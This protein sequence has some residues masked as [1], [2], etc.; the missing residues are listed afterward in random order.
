MRGPGD[1]AR[2]GAGAVAGPASTGSRRRSPTRRP[3]AASTAA[4]WT[5]PTPARP[6]SVNAWAAE[7]TD[8]MIREVRRVASSADEMI[9]LGR[10]RV[11]RGLLDRRRSHREL[12]EARAVHA[13]RR[14]RRSPCPTMHGARPA[15]YVEDDGVQAVRLRL[16]QRRRARVRRRD[17]PRGPRRAGARRG[18]L[19]ARSPPACARGRAGRAAA[20]AARRR[21]SSC[22]APLRGA[23]PRPGVPR[24]RR[25]RRHVRRAPRPPRALGRV[26]HRAR[27][28][29]DEAGHARGR[30]DRRDRARD[31][32]A[33]RAARARS[34][35]GSTARSCGRSSTATSGT[36]LFLGRVTDPSSTSEERT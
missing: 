7:R 6:T 32:P 36:L 28:D 18:R 12:T 5:S 15:G 9:A 10:R 16:R 23:R 34:T 13:P 31:R 4:R 27:V 14:Q 33:R 30:G 20:A 24:R 25:L 22:G 35:C 26:L 21:G 8:G 17:R 3:G 19:G 2:A 11:L 29:L 1:P